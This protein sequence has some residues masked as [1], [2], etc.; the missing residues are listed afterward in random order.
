[1]VYGAFA[2]PNYQLELAEIAAIH[3]LLMQFRSHG[4]PEVPVR[5]EWRHL[6]LLPALVPRANLNTGHILL[7]AQEGEGRSEIPA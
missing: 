7:L 6:F 2:E 4:R 3:V 1:M 5:R